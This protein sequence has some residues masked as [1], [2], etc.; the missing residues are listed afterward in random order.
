[1]KKQLYFHIVVIG[2]TGAGKSTLINYL[3][4]QSLRATGV[5]L[6]VTEKGFHATDVQLEDMHVTL[7]D[8][9]GIEQGRLEEWEK[10]FT[11]FAKATTIDLIIYCIDASS[12]RVQTTDQRIISA[13][14]EH[15]PVVA[16]LTKSNTLSQQDIHKMAALIP[17]RTLAVNSLEDRYYDGSQSVTYGRNRVINAIRTYY[18]APVEK[19]K[20]FLGGLR[21]GKNH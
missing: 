9:W 18:H 3:T 17:C 11:K 2:Q 20:S 16:V 8:A 21:F 7:T 10:S 14:L 4:G 1:M 5:G 19:K 12:A 6:P 15:Y 13:L